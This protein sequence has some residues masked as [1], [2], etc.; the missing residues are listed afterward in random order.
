MA[1]TPRE[2]CSLSSAIRNKHRTIR[3]K[4]TRPPGMPGGLVSFAN[5]RLPEISVSAP[6]RWNHP[7]NLSKP[8][9]VEDFFLVYLDTYMHCGVYVKC[10]ICIRNHCGA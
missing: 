4:Q 7:S 9:I 5:F 2:P 10:G 6:P 1:R 8:G 3:R